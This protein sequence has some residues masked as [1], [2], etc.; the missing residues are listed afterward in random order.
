MLFA[1]CR[2]VFLLVYYSYQAT[3]EDVALLF[4]KEIARGELDIK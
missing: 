3:Q 2:D 4:K 1:D